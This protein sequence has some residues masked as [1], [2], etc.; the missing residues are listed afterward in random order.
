MPQIDLIATIEVAPDKLPAASALLLAYGAQVR[1]EP[2][3]LR[4]EA[5]RDQ[6]SGAMVVVERY[7]DAAAFQAHLAHPA[8]AEFNARLGEVLGGGG[9]T[10]QLLDVLG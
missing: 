5:Y 7:A 8:N 3:N 6:A 9:S 4:F 2:G 1:T 10:L